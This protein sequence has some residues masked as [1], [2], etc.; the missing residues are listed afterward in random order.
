MVILCIASPWGKVD[1]TLLLTTNPSPLHTPSFFLFKFQVNPKG[2]KLSFKKGK[3]H[4][5]GEINE[6][7]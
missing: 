3:Q 2:G 5:G 6:M 7:I 1:I 4:E